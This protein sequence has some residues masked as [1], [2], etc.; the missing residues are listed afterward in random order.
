M[1]QT[2]KF[3]V[4]ARHD[5]IVDNIKSMCNHAGLLF[6]DPRLREL[7]TVNSDDNKAADGCI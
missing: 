4:K 6:T 3:E 2:I 5:A 1:L 7:R